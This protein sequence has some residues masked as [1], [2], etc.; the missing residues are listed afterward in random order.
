[1]DFIAWETPV[2]TRSRTRSKSAPKSTG[3]EEGAELLAGLEDL[4]VSDLVAI[5]QRA[6]SLIS[7]KRDEAVR[8]LRERI[9]K[10]A[11]ALGVDMSTLVRQGRGGRQKAKGGQPGMVRYRG[12]EGQEWSGR[13]RKPNWIREAEAQGK[14][15]QY[16]VGD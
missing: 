3:R 1:M 7:A 15:A 5:R 8:E 6:D 10:E 14:L 16:K 12:P 13:G 11:A 9:A 2:A 4:S